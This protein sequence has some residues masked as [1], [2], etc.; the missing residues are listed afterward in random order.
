MC[1]LV[2]AIYPRVSRYFR[3]YTI[4]P[5]RNLKSVPFRNIFDFAKILHRSIMMSF[6][7]FLTAEKTHYYG[8]IPLTLVFK[9]YRKIN[10]ANFENRLRKVTTKN[11]RMDGWMD[12]WSWISFCGHCNWKKARLRK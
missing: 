3:I 11:L 8:P 5:F 2:K 1:T 12:G 6:K 10:M 7:A 4:F 9:T